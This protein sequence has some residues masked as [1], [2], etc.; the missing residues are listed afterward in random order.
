MRSI[1]D[2]RTPQAVLL[3]HYPICA[4]NVEITTHFM[5]FLS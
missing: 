4:K 2:A 3:F 1:P 5:H